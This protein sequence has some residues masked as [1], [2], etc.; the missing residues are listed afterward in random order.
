M[1]C[2]RLRRQHEGSR[3]EPSWGTDTGPLQN[4]VWHKMDAWGCSSLRPRTL[5]IR[6]AG[7]VVGIRPRW[8]TRPTTTSSIIAV[9]HRS[10]GRAIAAA[11][12]GGEPIEGV[13]DVGRP[14]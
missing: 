4:S 9:L 14:P 13:E 11:G 10:L 2:R 6:C 1:G 5:V 3:D 8:T 7:C 12:P